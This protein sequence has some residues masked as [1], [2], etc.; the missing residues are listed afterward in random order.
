MNLTT[1]DAKLL[2]I[3]AANLIGRQTDRYHSGLTAIAAKI[4]AVVAQDGAA[5]SE[6][7]RKLE[8]DLTK[9]IANLT[10]DFISK[11]D[12]RITDI[13][14]DLLSKVVKVKAEV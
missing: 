14:I 5:L 8:L 2:R 7:K 12:L 9:A 1:D 4:E 10:E 13:K 11:T 6:R 3:V